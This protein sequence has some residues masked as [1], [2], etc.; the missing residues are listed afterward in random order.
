MRG[1][2]S[3]RLHQSAGLPGIFINAH[4]GCLCADR[5]GEMGTVFH[6]TLPIAN[7]GSPDGC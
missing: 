2:K 6:F 7:G 4:G 5:D 1:E 3:V